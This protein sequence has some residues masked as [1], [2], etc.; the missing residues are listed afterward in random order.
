VG[1]AHHR[2]AFFTAYVGM[3]FS[4]ASGHRFG[5][6]GFEVADL[7]RLFFTSEETTG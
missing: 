1:G 3:K 5:Q 4:L 2:I 6:P 7:R